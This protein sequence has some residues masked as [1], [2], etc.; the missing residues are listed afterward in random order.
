MTSLYSE[1]LLERENKH[2]LETSEGFAVYK[3]IGQECYI[4]DIYVKPYLRK[5]GVAS[6]LADRV[7]EI[8]RGNGCKWLSGSVSPP[9]KNSHDSLLV[10]LAYGMKLLRSDKDILF[11]GKEL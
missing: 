1:Y 4:V 7:A 8:A 9:A 5:E 10:L 6:K 11:L 3:F 2:V